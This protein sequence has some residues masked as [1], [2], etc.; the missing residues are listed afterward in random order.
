LRGEVLGETGC[1]GPLPDEKQILRSAYPM[2]D[3]RSRGPKLLRSGRHLVV[4]ATL[5]SF[6]SNGAD[7]RILEG[8]ANG[9]AGPSLRLPHE[10]FSFTGPQAAPLR[11]TLCC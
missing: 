7:E 8:S 6:D 9:E 4:D 11:M 3:F 1:A 10:R 2:N 5:V